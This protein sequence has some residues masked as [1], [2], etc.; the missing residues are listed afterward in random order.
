MTRRYGIDMS[1]LLRYRLQVKKPISDCNAVSCHL[2]LIK[3]SIIFIVISDIFYCVIQ[4][5]RGGITI[6]A[7]FQEVIFRKKVPPSFLT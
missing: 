3:V 6:A 2:I 5:F 1:V 4:S 7:D